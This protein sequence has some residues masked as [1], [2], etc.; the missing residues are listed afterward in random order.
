[1]NAGA[2]SLLTLRCRGRSFVLRAPEQVEELAR[3][4]RQKR[5]ANIAVSIS[6]AVIE[7]NSSGKLLSDDER[8]ADC[9]RTR[10]KLEH[11]AALERDVHLLLAVL[12]V[13]L[14]GM[15]GGILRE[16]DRLH[17]EARQPELGA[18]L[19]HRPPKV[20]S[21]SSR[22]LHVASAIACSP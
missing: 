4:L 22:R 10:F 19:S 13:V 15:A 7:D 6:G 5:F 14:P 18:D 2:N 12:R 1:M 20:A 17:A 21:I 11:A 16:I 9:A 3:R 8:E